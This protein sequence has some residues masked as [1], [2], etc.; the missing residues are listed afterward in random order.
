VRGL[1]SGSHEGTGSEA[2][3]KAEPSADDDWLSATTTTNWDEDTPLTSFFDD[4]IDRSTLFDDTT[5]TLPETTTADPNFSIYQRNVN[6]EEESEE[7]AIGKL[8][9]MGLI[10]AIGDSDCL[11]PSVVEKYLLPEVE[12][13]KGESMFY[14]RKAAVQALSSISKC[15]PIDSLASVVVSRISTLSFRSFANDESQLPLHNHYARDQMWHIRRAACQSLPDI[16]QRLSHSLLR[17]HTAPLIK[18]FANDIS[19][20]FV[21]SFFQAGQADFSEH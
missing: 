19:S 8:V 21:S 13:M 18:L 1:E 5:S 3:S 2:S 10:S 7:S 16:C 17:S 11:D 9:S 14:V 6:R 12:R 4:D 15:L 20:G